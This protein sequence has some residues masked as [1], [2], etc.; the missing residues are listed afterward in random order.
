MTGAAFIGTIIAS[1]TNEVIGYRQVFISIAL[2]ASFLAISGIFLK[3][4]SKELKTIM[5][6]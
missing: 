2:L 3:S 5:N 6:N 1:N 4:R